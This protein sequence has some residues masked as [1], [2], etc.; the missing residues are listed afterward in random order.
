MTKHTQKPIKNIITPNN[1]TK[2]AYLTEGLV[3]SDKEVSSINGEAPRA[4]VTTKQPKPKYLTEGVVFPDTKHQ[5][6]EIKPSNT[7]TNKPS[8][9]KPLVAAYLTDYVEF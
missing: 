4:P 3:F 2:T 5:S 8:T 9:Q 7:H 6:S 1:P